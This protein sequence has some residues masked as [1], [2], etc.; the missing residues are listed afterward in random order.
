MQMDDFPAQFE[1]VRAKPGDAQ[2]STYLAVSP[3]FPRF[4]LVSSSLSQ[5]SAPKHLPSRRRCGTP[6]E[7]VGEMLLP[8]HPA[9][10]CPAH[11]DTGSLMRVN[12]FAMIAFIKCKPIRFTAEEAQPCVGWFCPGGLAACCCR[13]GRTPQGRGKSLVGWE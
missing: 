9:A 6:M 2:L 13:R 5:V 1:A 8:A 7:G 10:A 11:P 3:P 12:P 4:A